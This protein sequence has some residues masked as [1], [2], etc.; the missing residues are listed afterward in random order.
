MLKL[1]PD[2]PNGAA[3]MV[4]PFSILISLVWALVKAEM[5]D[6]L[7]VAPE[8]VTDPKSANLRGV[9]FVAVQAEG[10]SAIHSAEDDWALGAPS[11]SVDVQFWVES[12]NVNV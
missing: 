6:P 8:K 3:L 4:L 11:T 5:G 12:V 10:A 9:H 2:K 1:E 7:A